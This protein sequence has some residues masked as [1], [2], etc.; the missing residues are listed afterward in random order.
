MLVGG[1]FSSV[2]GAV[3]NNFARV[4]ANGGLDTLYATG[5]SPNNEVQTIVDQGSGRVVIGGNFSLVGNTPRSGIARVAPPP[6]FCDFDGDGKADIA[7][8]RPS[9]GVWYILQST[10]GFTGM[11]YGISTDRPLPNAFLP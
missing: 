10:A 4:H 7:I 6:P 11:Q 5:N 9:S 2:N 8:Y 1:S 3:R